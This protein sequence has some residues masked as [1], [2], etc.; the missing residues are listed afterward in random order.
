MN[1]LPD[2]LLSRTSA[3]GIDIYG[4]AVALLISIIVGVVVSSLYQVFYENRATGS[5][6][7]RSFLLLSPSITA[8][9]IAIQFSLPLSL[10]LLGALSFVRFRTPIKEPEEIGFLMLTI[11]ASVVC[12][13]FNFLL[14]LVLLVL[15]FMAL[16]IQKFFPY[17]WNSKRQDGI[18]TITILS[19]VSAKKMDDVIKFLEKTLPEGKLQSISYS[20]DFNAINY[21]FSRA[22]TAF[23]NALHSELN[24]IAPVQK[25]N[26]FFNRQGSLF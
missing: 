22:K 24:E 17:L 13:T 5:Q 4:F 16:S 6:I 1:L 8:L 26:V 20:D 23:M 21:S 12:A 19:P 7:H 11:A 14:L 10:G 2:E 9:F 15:S 25:I 3:S 18:I